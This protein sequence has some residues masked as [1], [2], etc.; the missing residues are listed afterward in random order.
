MVLIQFSSL[1]SCFTKQDISSKACDFTVDASCSQT[2]SA[3]AAEGISMWQTK[4]NP[5]TKLLQQNPSVC[6]LLLI[7]FRVVGEGEAYPSCH[8]ATGGVHPGQAL[9]SFTVLTHKDRELFTPTVDIESPIN[10]TPCVLLRMWEYQERTPRH[11]EHRH[12]TLTQKDPRLYL[13]LGPSCCE[14][15]VL[16]TALTKSDSDT[17]GTFKT[18]FL[19]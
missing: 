6:F 10:Q 17:L 2:S 14:E 1:F 12:G 3:V 8:G 19:I 11:V 4:K 5:L 18:D 16:S 9:N 15:T 7:Q 13:S